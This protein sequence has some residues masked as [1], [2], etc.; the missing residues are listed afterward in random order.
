[1]ADT[2]PAAKEPEETAEMLASG[3]AHVWQE[4]TT[5]G[6]EP[7]RAERPA[8]RPRPDLLVEGQDTAPSPAVTTSSNGSGARRVDSPEA[9]PIDLLDHAGSS[10]LKRVV[11]LFAVVLGVLVLV[12]LR[13]R[14]R[15]RRH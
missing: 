4:N 13:R 8:L 9:E 15:R 14:S 1:V 12:G 3:L 10:V 11:P 2:V 7:V 5:E 6:S